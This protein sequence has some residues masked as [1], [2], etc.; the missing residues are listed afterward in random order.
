MTRW[1]WVLVNMVKCCLDLR[2]LG[3]ALLV[4]ATP[5]L[6][7]QLDIQQ[8]NTLIS[9]P[10]GHGWEHSVLKK[11]RIYNVNQGCHNICTTLEQQV[12]FDQ[13]VLASYHVSEMAMNWSTK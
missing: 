8:A 10:I 1:F 3:P 6:T 7:W 11:S 9:T 13:G 4:D 5:E 12:D 2:E